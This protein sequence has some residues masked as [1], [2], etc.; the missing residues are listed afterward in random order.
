MAGRPMERGGAIG[1]RD[2]HIHLLVEKRA[3]GGVVRG[4]GGIGETSI[5]RGCI[6]RSN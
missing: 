6:Q 2:V 5:G 4:H 3:H 1:L